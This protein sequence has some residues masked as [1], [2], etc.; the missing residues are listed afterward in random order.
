MIAELKLDGCVW[1]H[2][3]S[4]TSIDDRRMTPFL[5]TLARH[6]KPA[7][8]HVRGYSHETTFAFENLARRVP[9][10]TIVAMCPMN[11]LQ[12]MRE[13]QGVGERCP[14]IMFN[15]SLVWPLNHWIE[16]FTSWFGSQRIIF[17]SD[18]HYHEKPSY[19][20]PPGLDEV[21]TSDELSDQDK[22]NILWDNAE[23]LFP[24]LKGLG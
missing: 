5:Q 6:G 16:R 2:H 11:G 9:E 8:I 18:V 10:C 3:F 20:R 1:H 14:N 23:R 24:Q 13:L 15:T 17:G 22:R 21:L 19:I 12:Q 7:L 4:G